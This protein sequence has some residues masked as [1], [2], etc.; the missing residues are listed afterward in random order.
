MFTALFL[1]SLNETVSFYRYSPI[2]V[3]PKG[4]VYGAHQEDFQKTTE[5]HDDILARWKGTYESEKAGSGLFGPLHQ[6]NG[7]T[8]VSSGTGY[9]HD[10]HSP[11]RSVVTLGSGGNA[12]PSHV[13]LRARNG[14]VSDEVPLRSLGVATATMDGRTLVTVCRPSTDAMDSACVICQDHRAQIV[15][16]PCHHCVL[17]VSCFKNG[18]CKKF[19]PVCRMPIQSRVQPSLLRLIRPRI[20]SAYSFM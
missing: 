12:R 16:E 5:S 11:S 14:A 4:Y 15:F 1:L 9:S 7:G 3:P 10:D 6:I 8:G 19:C 13:H 20:Y 2:D 17:C 18:H